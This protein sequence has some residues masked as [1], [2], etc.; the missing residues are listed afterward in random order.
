MIDR[1]GFAHLVQKEGTQPGQSEQL[2]TLPEDLSRFDLERYHD[3][4]V[5]AEIMELLL[6][7]QT[8][9]RFT[10]CVLVHGMGGTGKTITGSV[11]E[12]DRV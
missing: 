3:R 9:R 6:L 8:D 1:S 4:P 11:H 2:A 10:S 12:L 5:Q 7:P